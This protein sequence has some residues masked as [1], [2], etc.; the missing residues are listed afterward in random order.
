MM[1]GG[2][3]IRYDAARHALAEAHRVD[4]VKDIRDKAQAMAAY[5][6]QAK[7][8]AMVEWAT[9]IKVRAE[10]RAGE[11][12]AD[13]GRSGD[14]NTGGKPSQHE[15]VSTL[16]DL[17]VSESQSSRWQRLAAV[18]EDRFEQAVAA[19]K[20]TAREVTTAAMLR[21]DK[22]HVSH[23][24]GENEWY[25][26][27]DIIER[28]REAMGGID[29]DPASSPLANR[30]VKAE[31]FYTAADDGLS[32]PW[33][34]RVW[35]NPPY[36]NPLCGQFAEAVALRFERKEIEQACVLVNNATETGWFVSMSSAASSL[37]LLQGRVKYLD[38][39]GSPAN[40]PLQ[41]Q[42]VIYFGPRVQEFS[43]AFKPAGNVWVPHG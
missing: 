27:P 39:T 3:L 22:P 13:M 29:C 4:E 41:G 26:P 38:S 42:A 32:R 25:T 11:L 30:N 2:A 43:A 6:R 33:H 40:S 1:D 31:T 20:E 5:A 7:D 14:R 28:A 10:R 24:S 16:A 17:G 19:A 36:S 15:R 8:T 12:L 23:N 9:E 21:L 37:C 34:G 35:L 18:P